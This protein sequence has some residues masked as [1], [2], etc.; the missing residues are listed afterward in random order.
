MNF[1]ISIIIPVYNAENTLNRCLDS[2]VNQEYKNYEVILIN[3]G[4]TDN[5][6]QILD[7]Y[8]DKYTNI[9]V[10]HKINEGV[11]SARNMGLEIA[12][13]EYI[14]FI[15]S[16]DFFTNKWIDKLNNVLI[17]NDIDLLVASFIEVGFDGNKVNHNI[18]KDENRNSCIVNKLPGFYFTEGF[19]H[20]CWG[21]LYKKEII[22]NNNI[23]FLNQSLSED[24]IFNINYLKYCK[25]IL[26]L[27]EKLYVYDHCNV[28]NLTSKIYPN[29]FEIYLDVEKN[30][31]CLN[32]SKNTIENTMYPQYYSA[33]IKIILS[34]EF[35]Y[36]EK[37]VILNNALDQNTIKDKFKI[38]N[39]NRKIKIINFLIRKKCFLIVLIILKMIT[40]ANKRGEI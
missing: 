22:I 27:N 17:G 14:M 32:L 25:N 13:G 6:K 3:D 7:E 36:M 35:K 19:I 10:K 9:I 33:V 40:Y 1:K 37:K 38:Y 29:I 26:F 20:P 28:N 24:T 12:S 21:K 34:N 11:S 31:K 30:L 39:N 2:I 8:K 15:D 18:L 5:S 23:R 4:S 16:D